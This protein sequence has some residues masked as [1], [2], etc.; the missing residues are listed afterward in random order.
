MSEAVDVPLEEEP[1][2]ARLDLVPEPS[3]EQL[4]EEELPDLEDED[5][6]D[7]PEEA[8]EFATPEDAEALRQARREAELTH[9]T[10]PVRAYLKGIGRYAL[11]NAEE[12]V[13]KSKRIEAGLLAAQVL[14]LRETHDTTD[15]QAS[16]KQIYQNE[17]MSEHKQLDKPNHTG[18]VVSKD[19]YELLLKCIDTVA[20]RYEAKDNAEL[21]LGILGVL[22]GA[23]VKLAT[24]QPSAEE[25]APQDKSAHKKKR[26]SEAERLTEAEIKNEVAE[27]YAEA[28]ADDAV[29]VIVQLAEKRSLTRRDLSLI[30]NDG[31]RA[32]DEMLQ[33]NLRLVV[34]LAKRYVG[35]GMDLLELIQ[36]GNLGLI[37]AVEKFDY[38]KG[39]KFS[40]YATWWIRQAISR[41]MADQSRTIRI[42]VHVV[43]DLQKFNRVERELFSKSNHE[44][45]MDE[46]AREMHI[47]KE[48]AQELKDILRMQP[49]SLDQ[50]VGDGGGAGPGQ[51]ETYLGD[52]IGDDGAE[53]ALD[54]TSR[55]LLREQL[56]SVLQTLTEREAGV[57]KLRYG[58][59]D[60][61]PRTLDEIGQVYGVTRER[62][63]QIERLTMDKLRHPSRAQ[64]LR[65]YMD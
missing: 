28:K 29:H 39:Y 9:T 36:E 51:T 8:D 47:T 38:A 15:L 25:G 21:A 49:V 3:P 17:F 42:P 18:R 14:L 16:L 2:K 60:G 22:R 44:P 37:R 10:D 32:K 5:E 54:A 56:E 11:I 33:A 63:R 43:E 26:K 35:K 27:L 1:R 34:S 55:V 61:Q 4:A 45:T 19:E 12:E 59:I 57:I 7:T 20:K 50:P 46:I 41:A 58:L 48:K 65:D 13:A 6:P 64:G 31:E 52:L 40:T 30:R 62:I 53:T 23:E 24:E